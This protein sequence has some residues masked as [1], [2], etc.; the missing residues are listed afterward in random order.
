[1]RKIIMMAIAGFLW[2]K[3]GGKTAQRFPL[4]RGYRRY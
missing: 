2:K 1:M 3:F 4:G